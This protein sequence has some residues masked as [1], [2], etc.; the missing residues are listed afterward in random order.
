MGA[1]RAESR[2]RVGGAQPAADEDS[3]SDEKKSIC[4]LTA[5]H[6]EAASMTMLATGGRG[7]SGAL[8]AAGGEK[9]RQPSKG[10]LRKASIPS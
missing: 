1:F 7:G 4:V 10:V 3:Q 2:L 5:N 8:A 6:S 9:L